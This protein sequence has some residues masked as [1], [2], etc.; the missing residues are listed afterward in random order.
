MTGESHSTQNKTY[1]GTTFPTTHPTG[2]AL[3][4]NEGLHSDK[5]GKNRHHSFFQNTMERML[6]TTDD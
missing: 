2:T 3:E 6:K 1:H 5:S 4:L